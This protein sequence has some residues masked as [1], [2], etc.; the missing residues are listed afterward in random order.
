MRHWRVCACVLGA[1]VCVCACVRVS[2]V[3]A[4]CFAAGLLCA[5]VWERRWCRTRRARARRR[6]A[7]PRAAPCT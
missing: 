4:C 7:I 1:R 5:S 2:A 3:G 6:C